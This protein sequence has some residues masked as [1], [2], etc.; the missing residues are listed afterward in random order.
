MNNGMCDVALGLQQA[1]NSHPWVMHE[2]NYFVILAWQWKKTSFAV[3]NHASSK[4]TE[5][6][7]SVKQGQ[8]QIYLWSDIK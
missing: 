1:F 6:D 5:I 7:L 2:Q 3:S 4:C 8:Y